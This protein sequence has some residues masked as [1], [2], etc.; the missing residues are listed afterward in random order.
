MGK[1]AYR[2]Y[3]KGR[4]S[5]GLEGALAGKIIDDFRWKQLSK[6]M[7]HAHLCMFLKFVWEESVLEQGK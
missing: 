2:A 3:L 7:Y 5:S 6:L 1:W 4:F